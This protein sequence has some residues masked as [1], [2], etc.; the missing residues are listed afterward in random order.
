MQTQLA[1]ARA[2]ATR[3]RAADAG[4]ARATE[5]LRQVSEQMTE[6]MQ[7]L[8]DAR[9]AQAAADRT[10]RAE[11]DRLSRLRGDLTTTDDDLGQWARDTYRVGGPIATYESLLVLLTGRGTGD[12]SFDLATMEQVVRQQGLTVTSLRQA[13]TE[14]ADAARKAKL[15]AAQAAAARQRATAALAKVRSLRDRAQAAV[16]QLQAERARLLGGQLTAEQ[17]A[18][19]DAAMRSLPG[20]TDPGACRGQDV[21]GYPNGAIPMPALCPLWGAPGLRL[22]ADA[23]AAFN[24]L[25]RAYA[26]EFGRPI[27]VT[28]GYRTFAT[29]V[30]LRAQKPTLAA[31][32]GTSNHGWGTAVDLCGG[33]ESFG[34][35]EHAW[36]QVHAPL[37]GWFHPSWA[38]ASGSK[39]EPWHWEFAG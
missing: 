6:A 9:S 31:Q 24:R 15:A 26:A 18:N 8:T 34:T 19:L 2:L 10:R 38:A 29:Q 20:S 32:P 1:Q 35:I 21:S 33:I 17:Q 25:S 13:V 36:M 37:S 28:D 5:Q 22:R 39:P 4:L 3:L 12:A 7:E 30:R 11:E 16:A 14:Q 27:C 23:A